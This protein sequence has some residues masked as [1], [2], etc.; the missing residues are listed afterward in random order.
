ML[1]LS[2]CVSV[3]MKVPLT[4]A[5]V[6]TGPF[7]SWELWWDSPSAQHRAGRGG[8]FHGSECCQCFWE[9]GDSLLTHPCSALRW[10]VGTKHIS[11]Y[12]WKNARSCWLKW[13]KIA[14][15]NFWRKRSI[16][17]WNCAFCLNRFEH[18]DTSHGFSRTGIHRAQCFQSPL[19]L[20]LAVKV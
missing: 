12:H 8:S 17:W 3:S 16:S 13:V 11:L 1:F 5:L 20:C 18:K 10:F 2:S 9:R 7:C 19:W 4:C 14:W 6:M 15:L